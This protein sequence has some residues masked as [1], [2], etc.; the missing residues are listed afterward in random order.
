M[1]ISPYVKSLREV[2]GHRLLLLPGVAAII[3][4]EDG[5]ILLHRRA[6]DGEWSLPAGAI[7]PGETPA[8]AITREVREETGLGVV[9]EFILGVFGGARFRHHYP[10]GDETEYTVVVFD[11]RVTE[12]KLE[13]Q[14]GEAVELRYFAPEEVPRLGMPYPPEVFGAARRREALF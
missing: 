9:P 7:D 13:A 11:C 14:D 6:D 12:G 10:N 4:D 1:S 5:G 3:R 8:E 2:V